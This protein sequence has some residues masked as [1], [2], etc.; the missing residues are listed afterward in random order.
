MR[1]NDC[2]LGELGGEA[3]SSKGLAV[4]DSMLPLGAPKYSETLEGKGRI[5]QGSAESWASGGGVPGS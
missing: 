1:G 2:K 3:G 5:C 4:A